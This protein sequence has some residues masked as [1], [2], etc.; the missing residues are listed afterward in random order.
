MKKISVVTVNYNGAEDTKELLASGESLDAG[1]IVVDN[2]S[3][4][5]AEFP[6]VEVVQNGENLGFA[7][8]Y[9]RG[10][11]YAVAGG[12]DY[13]LIINNDTLIPDK[14]LLTKLVESLEK[15]PDWGVV[16]PK[17]WFAPGYEFHKERYT[18]KEAGKV[19]WYA[20]GKFDWNNLWS[21]HRGIDE[22]DTGKYDGVEET[23]FVSGC[24]FLVRRE[25]LEKVGYFDEGLFAYYEDNDLMQRIKRAGWRCGYDGRVGIYHKVSRTAGIGSET[26]DYYLARN[27]HIFA[28]RYASM[29]TKL[30]VVREGLRLLITG[31]PMQKRGVRD[32]WRGKRGGLKRELAGKWPIKLSIAIINYKTKEFTQKLLHSIT[33]YCPEAEVVVVDNGSGESFG[34]EK[35]ISS[36]VNLGFSGGYNLA[37]DYCRGQYLLLLNSDIEIRKESVQKL[38][39]MNG[40]ALTAGKL[41]LPDGSV[42]KS[43]FHLPTVWGAV[44]EYILGQKEAFLWY[45]SGGGRVD[46]AVA[47]CWMLPQTVRNR[48]GRL[49]EATVLYLEDIEYCR[50][51]GRAGVPIYYVPGAVFDHYHGAASK[52]L[53]EGEAVRKQEQA[54]EWYYG[55][56]RYKLIV[57]IRW[58]GHLLDR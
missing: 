5:E 58:I 28:M 15:H 17:I 29:R 8:G 42:Q 30:A 45:E 41:I 49:N 26:A 4:H 40:E 14:N 18:K 50:R 57:G 48:V 33:K 25:V 39:T 7:G 23:G 12:A 37:L 43:V 22:V 6:G 1:W 38:L 11:R 56:W 44:K 19:I 31:R 47:A 51:L 13:I 35:F 53:P 24:C 34:V 54:S 20:G 27:K 9:N 10:L 52:K 2:G 21:V 32:F 16:S 36:P 46:G 55:K 3:I